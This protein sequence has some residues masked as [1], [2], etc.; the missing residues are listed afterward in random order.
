MGKNNFK[1][2]MEEEERN[3]GK[4][5]EKIGRDLEYN[6]GFASF[7][8]NVVET[9]FSTVFGVLISM[10]GGDSDS[11]CFRKN[12]DNRMSADATPDKGFNGPVGKP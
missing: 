6:V 12:G 8:G 11:S 7:S 5:P 4:P 9:F 10:S 1:N 2:L 3:A